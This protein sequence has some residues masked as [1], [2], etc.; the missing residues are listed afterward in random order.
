MVPQN[1][2]MVL[3]TQLENNVIKVATKQHRGNLYFKR[4]NIDT[5][6]IIEGKRWTR[7]NQNIVTSERITT[8]TTDKRAQREK[9]KNHKIQFLRSNKYI[10]S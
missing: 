4:E 7:N 5:T 8:S 6:N 3:T 1:T 9:K 2:G 10:L